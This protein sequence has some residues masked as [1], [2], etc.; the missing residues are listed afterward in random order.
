MRKRVAHPARQCPLNLLRALQKGD[1]VPTEFEVIVREPTHDEVRAVTRKKQLLDKRRLSKQF[2]R[3]EEDSL[4][5]RLCIFE[6]KEMLRL[7]TANVC[8]SMPG[9][10]VWSRARRL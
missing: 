2:L 10:R 1:G 5:P 6:R 4:K 7:K 9:S 3:L 8:T